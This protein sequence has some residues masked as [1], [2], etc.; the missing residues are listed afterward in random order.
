MS[1]VEVTLLYISETR[2]R[3]EKTAKE[4]EKDGAEPHLVEALRIAER[5]LD[6]VATKLMQ[7]TYFAVPEA[8]LTLKS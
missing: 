1:E 8:Q 2:R 3:A 4:L 5:D 6:Q 7:R